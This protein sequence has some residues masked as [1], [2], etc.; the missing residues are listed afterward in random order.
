MEFVI[1][2]VELSCLSS[3]ILG[4]YELKRNETF[5]V[6]QMVLRVGCKLKKIFIM[7]SLETICGRIQQTN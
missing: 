7:Y 5:A 2:R 4:R 3:S 6:I 1:I